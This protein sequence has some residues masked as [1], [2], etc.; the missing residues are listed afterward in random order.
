VD[1]LTRQLRPLVASIAGIDLDQSSIDL[2]HTH[3][4]GAGIDH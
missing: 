1:I 4:D 3:D 2:A